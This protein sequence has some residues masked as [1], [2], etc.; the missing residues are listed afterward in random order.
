MRS[1]T[2]LPLTAALVGKAF[3]DVKFTKPAAGA[4]I[5]VGTISIEWQDSGDS[6][7][8]DDLT[9]YEIQLIQGGNDGTNSVPLT[10]LSTKGSHT[11]G[12]KA[13]GTVPVGI[14]EEIK[15][16]FYL[17]MQSVAKEGGQVINYSS[18]FS[19]KGLTGTSPD[20]AIAGAKSVTG[21]AGPDTQN[22]VANN[23]G[24]AVPADGD[25]FNMAY[26][27]QTGP[28]R[29]APMQGIPPTKITAKNYTPLHPTS[30]FSIAK[31]FLPIAKI[32]TTITQSQT[33]SVSSMENTAAPQ[34][35]PSGD[36]QRFLNRW[37]D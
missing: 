25:V 24:A 23:A 28:T 6:P 9:T 19:I 30:S 16:S 15:N 4:S 8:L 27:D 26:A 12:T 33:F 5:N 2:L 10:V 22:Q 36:M 7:S 21:T 14:A 17:K 11:A 20:T 37:K 32:Q 35:G 31:T 3:A 1:F 29:Y 13:Q 34:A 18:R